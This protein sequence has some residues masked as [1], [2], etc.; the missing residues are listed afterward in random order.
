MD[1]FCAQHTAS[2]SS[3]VLSKHADAISC[4]KAL[5]GF[6]LVRYVL[7]YI[8]CHGREAGSQRNQ[9]L[10]EEARLLDRLA[11][12]LDL[13]YRKYHFV[14][15]RCALDI[16]AFA[17]LVD[18]VHYLLQQ[19]VNVE[20][21]THLGGTPLVSAA[22]GG[23]L[24]MVRMLL[25]HG[26]E[27]TT[28]NQRGESALHGAAFSGDTELLTLL[29]EHDA[30]INAKDSEGESVLQAAIRH[31]RSI[32]VIQ[33]LLQ[34]GADVNARN[35]QDEFVLCTAVTSRAWRESSADLVQLLLDYNADVN[36]RDFWDR[37]ALHYAVIRSQFPEIACL[38]LRYGTDANARDRCGLTALHRAAQYGPTMELIHLLL[39]HG[40]DVNAKSREGKSVLHYF[41]QDTRENEAFV[42]LC[43]L[44]GANVN[45]KDNKG[46]SPLHEAVSRASMDTV[47]LLLLYG[48]DVNAKDSGSESVLHFALRRDC[49]DKSIVQLLLEKGAIPATQEE[50]ERCSQLVSV[51]RSRSA[52]GPGSVR[53]IVLPVGILVLTFQDCTLLGRDTGSVAEWSDRWEA[54]RRHACSIVARTSILCS[55][56][57]PSAAPAIWY[58]S[59]LHGLAHG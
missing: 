45:A 52:H 11:L 57:F 31:P 10:Q 16:A 33:L 56:R 9:D 41:S 15:L 58:I 14:P 6:R 24:S 48:A 26:V 27:V 50:G 43:L 49:V 2:V 47:Q 4:W 7:E 35:N 13:D 51:D 37:T 22:F 21:S 32:H 30:D 18:L 29:L 44:Y 54:R 20:T 1:L 46:K 53:Y 8:F 28:T 34:Y 23:C 38:L 40:I 5:P 42:W 25:K 55:V 17:N 59:L 19:D 3:L 12:F 39:H 36:A